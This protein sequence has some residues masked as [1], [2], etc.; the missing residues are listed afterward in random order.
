MLFLNGAF[1]DELSKRVHKEAATDKSLAAFESA[2][3]SVRTPNPMLFTHR[4]QHS[5]ISIAVLRHAFCKSSCGRSAW[6]QDHLRAA[7]CAK[8]EQYRMPNVFA[9]EHA[10]SSQASVE[11]S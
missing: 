9:D 2:K 10:E 11:N 6:N 8:R 7:Q 3:M 5:T 4:A 1:R